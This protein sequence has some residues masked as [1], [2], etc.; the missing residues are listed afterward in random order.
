MSSPRLRTSALVAFCGAL[1]TLNGCPDERIRVGGFC[2]SGAEC[3]AGQ[4]CAGGLCVGTCTTNDDCGAGEVCRDQ[5]CLP[6]CEVQADCLVEGGDVA[7]LCDEGACTPAERPGRVTAGEA[8][9]VDEG[10]R[11]VL[12]AGGSAAIDPDGTTYTWEQVASNPKGVT[13]VL[14]AGKSD[15]I[16]AP[17][18]VFDAPSVVQD[19]TLL[20]R[21]TMQDSGG[22]NAKAEVEITVRNSVNEAPVAAVAAGAESAQAGETVTLSAAGS[23]DPNPGDALS[24]SWS[25]ALEPPAEGVTITLT[26]LS[27]AGDMSEVSFVAPELPVDTVITFT[28]TFSDGISES[29]A[30]VQVTI[31]AKPEPTCDPTKC[32]DGNPCTDDGCIPL[33]GCTHDQLTGAACDDGDPCT[34]GDACTQGACVGTPMV[35]DDG[36]L[37]TNEQC[38][39]GSCVTTHNKKPC[40]DGDGCTVDDVC[41]AGSCVGKPRDCNDGVYCTDNACVDGDCVATPNSLPCDDGNVCTSQDKCDGGSCKGVQKDCDDSNPCTNDGCQQG[42]CVY[43]NNSAP[44]E[45]GNKCTLND[46]CAEG[47]CKPGTKDPCSDGNVCTVDSCVAATGCA[48]EPKSAG[49]CDDGDACTTNDLCVVGVC[50]GKPVSCDDGNPCT[51]DACGEGGCAHVPNSL[52]CD[53]GD[54]CTVGDVCAEGVCG[55]V[56]PK[57]CDDGDLCTADSCVPA[58]DCVHAW[59]LDAPCDDG[60][61]CTVEDTCLDTFCWGSAVICDDGSPCTT[62]FCSDGECQTAPAAG[63]CDDGDPCTLDDTCKGGACVPGPSPC[64]DGL[65]CTVDLCNPDAPGECSWAPAPAGTACMDAGGLCG[66]AGV[67][68]HFEVRSFLPTAPVFEGIRARLTDV[69]DDAYG[70]VSATAALT[71]ETGEGPQTAGF[72][73]NLNPG[74]PHAVTHQRYDGGLLTIG[75][76]IAAGQ[77]G[78]ITLRDGSSWYDD[79]WFSEQLLGMDVVTVAAGQPWYAAGDPWDWLLGGRSP[80]GDAVVVACGSSIE[81]CALESASGPGFVSTLFGVYV[82]TPGGD[83]GDLLEPAPL[84]A[85]STLDDGS[86]QVAWKVGPGGW[87]DEGGGWDTAGP[88][89]CL[90]GEPE[91]PCGVGARWNDA[92]GSGLTDLWLAGDGGLLVRF[93]GEGWSVV[94]L[95]G[96]S[97]AWPAEAYTLRAVER[98]GADLW[99]A[100]EVPGCGAGACATDPTWRS[101]VLLHWSDEGGWTPERLLAAR[102]CPAK[103]DPEQCASQLATFT[104]EAAAMKYDGTL[105]IVGGD[106]APQE[107]GLWQVLLAYLVR[108]D[109]NVD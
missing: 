86:S 17:D 43:L 4:V 9:A 56:E 49:V 51:D 6:T 23:S 45:D 101:H 64:D 83:G 103:G 53:D 13:V 74:A 70:G 40:D 32:D 73:V 18:V 57:D 24:W 90:A 85:I 96:L 79:F 11:V 26:D 19:T 88:L 105:A 95:G 36:E 81:G 69:M 102:Q 55:G 10:E 97:G 84:L 94:A 14:A 21:L 34:L 100:A 65:E 109:A 38:E 30:T 66:Y 107:Q 67:C 54:A 41:T 60:D 104:I 52:F 82:Y 3:P 7:R 76:G 87:A 59:L 91:T 80:D 42:V 29:T 50:T 5:V 22:Y 25:W 98:F 15:G 71:W 37:C 106:L 16:A 78:A 44:C 8:R 75:P 92:A 72:I 39:G 47:F 89:G 63:P 108:L 93:G 28:V 31:L 61:P 2:S 46:S 99:I 20:F 77:G 33:Q 1:V 58:S 12:S 68:H 62:D 35:C 48:W 27:E